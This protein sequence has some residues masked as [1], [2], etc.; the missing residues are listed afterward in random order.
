MQ[1]LL[2]ETSPRSNVA[3][4]GF[5]VDDK[6]GVGAKGRRIVR[7]LGSLGHDGRERRRDEARVAVVLGKT[8]APGA[9][10][11][12]CPAEGANGLARA[13][14][15]GREA[16]LS[17]T[18]GGGGRAGDAVAENELKTGNLCV[19]AEDDLGPC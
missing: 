8:A 17:A 9:A 3:V 18:V 16:V 10:C 7:T 4:D 14:D 2:H 5:A 15:V 1:D 11:R 6:G 13:P 12:A 19:L